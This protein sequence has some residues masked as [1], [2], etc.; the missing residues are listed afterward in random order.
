[1]ANHVH[2]TALTV[3][4]VRLTVYNVLMRLTGA[5]VPLV[6]QLH[7]GPVEAQ[8]AAAAALHQLT[9]A[10]RPDLQWAGGQVAT[11]EAGGIAPLVTLVSD[12]TELAQLHAMHALHNLARCKET[13]RAVAAEAADVAPACADVLQSH[14]TAAMLEQVSRCILLAWY[15]HC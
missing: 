7:H 2:S 1:M 8:E 9:G 3:Y 15:A 13:G 6:A 5:A 11:A 10:R 14:H 12:G 4:T